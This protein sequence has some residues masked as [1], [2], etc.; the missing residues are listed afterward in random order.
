VIG[1]SGT[2]LA[3]WEREYDGQREAGP[4]FNG[5]EVNA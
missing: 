2:D 5:A 4:V 1:A 3:S